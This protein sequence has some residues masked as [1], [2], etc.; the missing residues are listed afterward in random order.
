MVTCS[1]KTTGLGSVSPWICKCPP[2]QLCVSVT[3][4]W[5]SGRMGSWQEPFHTCVLVDCRAR[6]T[7]LVAAVI[8]AIVYRHRESETDRHRERARQTDT[9]RERDRQTHRE[10]DLSNPKSTRAKMVH[11][12]AGG[13]SGIHD[14]S[15][16]AE[17]RDRSSTSIRL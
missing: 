17:N 14:K 6:L 8:T 13:R 3:L 10:T 2:K 11:R 4:S 1:P 5:N 7:D 15:L 12:R 16:G 9:E